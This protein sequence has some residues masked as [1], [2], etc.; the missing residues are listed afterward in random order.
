M[1][2]SSRV[3]DPMC[4]GRIQGDDS[5]SDGSDRSPVD[6]GRTRSDACVD[7]CDQKMCSR[8]SRQL[9][10]PKL[11]RMII[12]VDG[13]NWKLS[14]EYVY[15]NPPL[16]HSFDLTTRLWN[17]ANMNRFFMENGTCRVSIPEGHTFHIRFSMF[18][19]YFFF[20][21]SC[22]LYGYLCSCVDESGLSDM[23][24]DT[25]YKNAERILDHSLVNEGASRVTR[26]AICFVTWV[27]L[28]LR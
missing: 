25:L 21:R 22:L 5:V 26:T 8:C 14:S 7:A 27:C 1:Q 18:Y 13:C 28:L 4:V 11:D 12:E 16:I 15:N 10:I 2:L 17:E 24:K 20:L 6:S 9:K 19:F 23:C 3:Y